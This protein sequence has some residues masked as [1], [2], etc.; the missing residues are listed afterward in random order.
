MDQPRRYRFRPGAISFS[1]GQFAVA[2]IALLVAVAGVVVLVLGDE[3]IAAMM[4]G[5]AGA[6]MGFITLLARTG[7]RPPSP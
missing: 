5:T 1:R 2:I 6:A 3:L 4:L 7:S